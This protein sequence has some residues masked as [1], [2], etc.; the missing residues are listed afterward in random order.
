MIPIASQLVGV[1]LISVF[2]FVAIAPIYALLP[3]A[4]VLIVSGTVHGDRQ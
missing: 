1:A 2:A 3:V 4:L